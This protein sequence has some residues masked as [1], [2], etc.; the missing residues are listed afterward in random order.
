VLT[1]PF[2]VGQTMQARVVVLCRLAL[3]I[4]ENVLGPHHPDT[5]ASLNKLVL[6]LQDRADTSTPSRFSVAF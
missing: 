1:C 5:A 4:R 6:L 3:D 2:E